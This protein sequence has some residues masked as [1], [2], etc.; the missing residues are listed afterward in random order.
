MLSSQREGIL[1]R[2]VT[3]PRGRAE[4]KCCYFTLSLSGLAGFNELWLSRER[5][6]EQFLAGTHPGTGDTNG[7]IFLWPCLLVAAT[8]A[9][10]DLSRPD[11]ENLQEAYL[12]L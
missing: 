9:A 6:K 8:L 12:Q 11:T 3:K 7:H 1:T 5:I 10:L 4:F 2:Q